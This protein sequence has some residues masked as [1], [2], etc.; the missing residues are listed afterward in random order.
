MQKVQ[1]DQ[2]ATWLS[3]KYSFSL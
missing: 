2:N 3:R 1:L